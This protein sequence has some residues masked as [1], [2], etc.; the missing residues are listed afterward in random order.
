MDI[1]THNITDINLREE[2][3]SLKSNA[4]KVFTPKF[5]PFY[6]ELKKKYKLSWL[7]CMIFG[8][9]SFYLHN[10][11]DKFYFTN[12]QLGYM[13]SVS[14]QSISNSVSR[15][16]NKKLIEVKLSIKSNG[17]QMRYVRL[18]EKLYLD[19][20]KSYS[21]TIRKVIGNNNKINNNKI[22]IYNTIS[23]LENI[24]LE[25]IKEF[26]DKF[27]ITEQQLKDKA[28]ELANYCRYKGRVYKDYKA[29]LRNALSKEFGKRKPKELQPWE[30]YED[31]PE[32]VKKQNLSKLSEMKKGIGL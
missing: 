9:V 17:G 28:E 18:K 20:K 16:N 4:E 15:L 29:F 21:P 12:E 8:F 31:L 13:F 10:S 7:D 25:D 23:Y 19:Y 1:I 5:I 3:E 27:N 6:P 2:V 24:P 26:V 14:S 22:N 32:E 11:S 30:K